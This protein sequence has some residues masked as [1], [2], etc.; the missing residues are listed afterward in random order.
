[1]TVELKPEQERLIREHL[2]SGLYASI[3]EVL[4]AALAQLKDDERFELQHRREAVRRMLEF[5]E[6]HKLRLGEPI[7]RELMHEGHRH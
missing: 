6:R 3:D 5:G 7:T 2:A 1:M 4:T